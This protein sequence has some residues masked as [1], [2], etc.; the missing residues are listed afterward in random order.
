MGARTVRFIGTV[1][2]AVII[3]ISLGMYDQRYASWWY[4]TTSPLVESSLFFT[5]V[6]NMGGV[7][8][9]L[10][11]IAAWV[12]PIGLLVYAHCVLH[13]HERGDPLFLHYCACCIFA[14]N[15]VAAICAHF[16]WSGYGFCAGG[17]LGTLLVRMIIRYSGLRYAEYLLL[18]MAIGMTLM[19]CGVSWTRSIIIRLR[20]GLRIVYALL[21]ECGY[22]LSLTM[23]NG[24]RMIITRWQAQMQ[25][26]TPSEQ[27]AA[28]APMPDVFKKDKRM[29]SI[30]HTMKTVSR[31][32][33]YRLPELREIFGLPR[34]VSAKYMTGAYETMA[35][36]LEQKLLKFGVQGKVVAITPGPVVVLFEYRP[37]SDVPISKIVAREHDLALAL[38]VTHIRIIAPLP[39]T[40]SVGFECVREQRHTILFSEQWPALE[41]EQRTLPLLI[42]VT[43][44][45]APV[46]L[47]LATLPH[48]LV[49]GSTGSGKSVALNSMLMSLLCTKRPEEVRLVLI[50]PKR[51]EFSWYSDLAHLL[52]PVVTDTREAIEV[53][54]WLVTEM[55]RRYA[56]MADAGVKHIIDYTDHEGKKEPFIV[57]VIDEWADLMM[58]GGRDAET[59]VVR[60]GQ[61]ARAAGIHTIIATQRPSV[62]VITGLMKVNFPA[63]IACKVTS[64]VDSRTILDVSGAEK[65]LGKGDM[66]LMM[67]SVGIHRV[68]GIWVSTHEIQC[69]TDAIRLQQGPEYVVQIARTWEEDIKVPAEDRELYQKVIE[70]VETVDTISISLLQRKLRI[71]YNRSARMIDYLEAH[72]MILPSDGGKMRKVI[73]S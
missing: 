42:G 35:R 40:S 43:T 4:S 20:H 59:M 46:V 2:S 28:G 23:R 1:A 14:M 15:I 13:T 16:S 11:G 37:E 21:E 22:M 29:S 19:I 10:W 61:M 57:L 71:G 25:I 51:L 12:L 17:A 53:L 73:R 36:T 6:C 24:A 72:G 41:K 66:L 39:G 3:M 33:S 5:V 18:C 34:D 69:I 62:E 49:A 67:P 48:I 30:G 38:C 32:S 65:L 63:R 45:G 31:S 7:L 8:L 60:L 27:P 26:S 64:K 56:V 68:H 9:F 70:L 44:A 58:T 55:E 47:D 50:D 54:R 52:F